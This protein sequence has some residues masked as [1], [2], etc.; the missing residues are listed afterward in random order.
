MTQPTQAQT[1]VATPAL[2]AESSDIGNQVSQSEVQSQPPS[3]EDSL[4]AVPW[5]DQPKLPP[6]TL[7]IESTLYRGGL[8]SELAPA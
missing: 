8:Y 4:F 3:E 7:L 6:P 5:E 2:P 1:T